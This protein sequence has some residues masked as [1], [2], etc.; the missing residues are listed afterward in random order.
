M[1]QPALT[2]VRVIDISRVLAG[3]MCGQMLADHGADVYKVEP[4]T[5][6]ETR[7]WGP[8]F[9]R[10]NQSA[11]FTGLNR[12]KKNISLNL[13]TDGGQEVLRR[14]LKDADVLIEN[15]KAGTLAKWGLS[16]EVIREEFPQLV[17][18]RI[19][20]YGVDGP[21]GGA[22]GYDAVM[23]AYSGLMSINGEADGPEMR[24]GI[25][26]VDIV[27]SLNAMSGILMA[28]RARDTTGRG[29]L[30][31]MALLDNA[32][33]I[34]HPHAYTFLASGNNPK[35]TGV[36]HP[37]IAPYETFQAADGPFFLAVGNDNQFRKACAVLGAEAELCTPEFETNPLRVEN[38]AKLRAKLSDIIGKWNRD[39]LADKMIEAGVPAGP[40]NQVSD[41]LAE[42]QALHRNMVVRAGEYT[43]LGL[44]I[45]L[46][47][48]PGSVRFGPRRRGEDNKDILAE[49]GYSEAE[50]HDLAN[51]GVI[52]AYMPEN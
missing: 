2:G 18:C 48:T 50:Q 47:D 27:T 35:R 4:P 38:R 17:H 21:L 49:F 8:P 9:F 31:D 22:P 24:I 19:T 41:A 14:M 40:V 44:P 52:S 25:P 26:L 5:G 39:E 10:D 37:T 13:R 15:F 1:T 45:K 46:T 34:L 33:S 36:S 6:D 32:L 11:Y 42:P 12:N 23:Q 30:I 51:T 3:P 16:D 43:G 7:Y 29:Q 20:G 28:L